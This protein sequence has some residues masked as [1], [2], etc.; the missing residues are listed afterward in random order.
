MKESEKNRPN[1]PYAKKIF[2]LG[3]GPPPSEEK[4]GRNSKFYFDFFKGKFGF[5][6][7]CSL[8]CQKLEKIKLSH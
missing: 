4:S 5:D 7:S 2:L 1:R 3:G 8:W 6:Q